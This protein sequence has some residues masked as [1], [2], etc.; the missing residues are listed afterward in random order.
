M[1]TRPRPRARP[2]LARALALLVLGAVVA[3]AGRDMKPMPPVGDVDLPRFMGEWYVI[4]QIPTFIERDAYDSV[5]RYALRE[6]GRIRTTFTW[7][8]GGFDEKLRTMHP[9]GTVREGTGDAVW[10]MQFVWPF[11][12]EYVIAWLDPGYGQTIV[13]RSKRDY[14]WLMART[15]SI[16]EADYAA[17]VE[18]IRAL[19][20]DVSKLRRVPQSAAGE[21]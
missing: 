12:A 9:V 14:V 5:E 8:H 11:K 20:Y 6:D 7:R 1:P 18:R 15:P 17:H 19:G 10:G 3:C 16:P 2:A 13:A 4:A 21:R